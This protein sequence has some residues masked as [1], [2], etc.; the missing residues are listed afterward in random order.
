MLY[1]LDPSHSLLI[2]HLHSR[3]HYYLHYSLLVL[4]S[5]MS[6]YFIYNHFHFTDYLSPLRMLRMSLVHS[7]YVYTYCLSVNL[8]LSYMCYYYTIDNLMLLM[9]HLHL[10]Y[11][12]SHYS[13]PLV[14]YYLLLPL[15]L[16]SSMS[17]YS[18][19]YMFHFTDYHLPLRIHYMFLAHS[20]Y[21]YMYYLSHY[22]SHLLLYNSPLYTIGNLTLLMYQLH[23]LYMLSLG[24][25][26][27]VH[28]YLY[29][30]SLVLC[31]SMSL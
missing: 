22:L 27:L 4:C 31:S 9:H 8:S 26:P 18:L 29:L 13:L 12:L 23:S 21:I 10:L 17:L 28:Y 25:L 20:L 1:F 15:A 5:S 16:C 7:M 11:M 24:S 14:R 6:L 19:H 2:L 3:S 30:H